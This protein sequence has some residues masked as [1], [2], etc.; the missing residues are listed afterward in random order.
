MWRGTAFDRLAQQRIFAGRDWIDAQPGLLAQGRALCVFGAEERTPALLGDL[1]E[2]FLRLFVF[3]R[4][5][6]LQPHLDVLRSAGHHAYPYAVLVGREDNLERCRQIARTDP[7][8][9]LGASVAHLNGPGEPGVMHRVQAF[10]TA[11]TRFP[12]PDY[13]V[14]AADGAVL[15]SALFDD[16]GSVIGTSIYHHLVRAG[17]EYGAVACGLNA[18]I[19]PRRNA[20]LRDAAIRGRSLSLAAWLNASAILR[21]RELFGVTEIWSY[22]RAANRRGLAFQLE[23]GAQEHPDIECFRIEHRTALPDPRHA[24][25]AIDP[26]SFQAARTGRIPVEPSPFSAPGCSAADVGC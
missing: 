3:A 24:G 7:S 25:R 14:G 8:H 19:R 15:T 13:F 1:T 10:C 21:C 22:T 2:Q 26:R 12:Q 20:A 17:P 9:L 6:A 4:R 16:D 23:L 18:A 11:A 5:G